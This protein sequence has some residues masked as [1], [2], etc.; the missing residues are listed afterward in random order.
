[1]DE[2]S[3]ITLWLN[4]LE[5]GETTAAQL[6]WNQ[7]YAKLVRL[8]RAKLGTSPR[9]VA[10]EEDVA[11][12]AFQSFCRG[13]KEGRFPQLCNRDDLWQILVMM[14]ARKA[15][16]QRLSERRQKR[17]GGRVRGESVFDGPGSNQGGIGDLIGRAPTAEFAAEVKE[18]FSRLLELL[19]DQ[20]L[21]EIA[22]LKLEGYSNSEIADQ[23]GCGQRTVERKLARIRAI[24]KECETYGQSKRR[25]PHQC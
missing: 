4:Q 10:D 19:K 7:Y 17:G 5:Q 16:D 25:G 8:A 23:L 9:R 11:T 20:E 22:L 13:V 2:N 18:E 3:A 14:T 6:L 1:M 24:W 12:D 21:R 15:I